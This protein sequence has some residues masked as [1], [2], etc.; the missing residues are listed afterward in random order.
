MLASASG[1]ASSGRRGFRALAERT[2]LF[3]SLG[4]RGRDELFGSAQF[5]RLKSGEIIYRSGELGDWFCLLIEGRAR[6]DGGSKLGTELVPG[7]LFG[8]EGLLSG[9]ARSAT[10]SAS[11]AGWLAVFPRTLWRRVIERDG[12]GRRLERELRGV[13]RRH[14]ARVISGL[15]LTEIGRAK[16]LD[17][18]RLVETGRG[19]VL[20]T[21][22]DRCLFIAHGLVA[23]RADP[24]SPTNTSGYRTSG[25][26]LGCAAALGSSGSGEVAVAVERTW[27]VELPQSLISQLVVS[28]PEFRK[29]LTDLL[30]ARER[31]PI[32]LPRL[33]QARSLLVID[34]DECVRCGHCAWACASAHGTTRL[35]RRGP[36]EQLT[37]ADG[38]S[39]QLLLANSCH[40]CSSPACMAECP[41]AAIVRHA[42]GTVSIAEDRCTG[43][44]ACAK[45]C[46][47]GSIQMSAGKAV[48]PGNAQIAKKCDVC[49]DL[50]QPACVTA[51]PTGAALRLDPSSDILEYRRWLGD[52]AV[53]HP[54]SPLKPR[55][56][57]ATGLATAL[58][59]FGILLCLLVSA[60]HLGGLS[61]DVLDA[62]SVRATS[63]WLSGGVCALLCAYILPKRLSFRRVPRHSPRH[64]VRF[65]FYLHLGLGCFSLAAVLAHTQYKLGFGLAGA[66]NAAF[67]LTAFWGALGA[68]A[69]RIIPRR[70]TRLERHGALPEDLAAERE[71]LWDR[72][73]TQVSG[74]H[75]LL[76]AIARQRLLPYA[77]S[78][79]GAVWLILSNRSLGEEKGR[80]LAEMKK[81]FDGDADGRLDGL[82]TLVETAVQLRALPARRWLSGFLRSVSPLHALCAVAT[83]V[84]LVLHVV[85][86]S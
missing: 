64:N 13:E 50:G 6:L 49:H 60:H 80:L 10:A 39:R 8:E 36:V 26:W 20:E 52:G 18:A 24:D 85:T 16:L 69:Y 21:N 47:W 65:A 45:A 79:F 27:L 11:S 78:R 42:D 4:A 44:E 86:A 3:L 43:C 15:R 19:S 38:S 31:M 73:F 74:K 33:R 2:P 54:A 30:R 72:A 29:Q 83:L 63:G 34:Q 51:C 81:G 5:R 67:L 56:S 7:E 57:L 22:H 35:L 9:A 40:Q 23:L 17:A 32:D 14:L 12:V 62:P 84:L 66:L 46:P 59:V 71:A 55:S 77:R 68:A 28:E 37:L 58:G 76:K 41:T 25:D 70:L 1:P 61:L 75:V 82:Q 48:S 53:E